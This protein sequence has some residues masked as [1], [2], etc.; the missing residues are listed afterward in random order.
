MERAPELGQLGARQRQHGPVERADRQRLIVVV[1]WCGEP[2]LGDLVGERPPEL[3][4]RPG[5]LVAAERQ[6]ELR[7]IALGTKPAH[8]GREH[9][10]EVDGAHDAVDHEP[11]GRV[12]AAVHRHRPGGETSHRVTVAAGGRGADVGGE[13]GGRRTIRRTVERGVDGIR[14]LGQRHARGEDEV[15]RPVEDRQV[16][17]ARDHHRSQRAANQLAIE[18][19]EQH[20]RPS[21]IDQV[22]G[23]DLDPGSAQHGREA[24]HVIDHRAA[25]LG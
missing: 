24:R 17:L 7:Q 13:G 3:L 23:R 8:H 1:A 22:A 16:R 9:V 10:G 12:V 19:I 6:L 20:Q 15:E 25:D 11:V 18:Q 2:A 5:D 14:L 21:G 4:E